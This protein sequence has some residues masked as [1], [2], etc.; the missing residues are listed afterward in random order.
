MTYPWIKTQGAN[1]VHF[2]KAWNEVETL[3]S[4]LKLSGLLVLILY[5]KVSLWIKLQYWFKIHD[6]KTWAQISLS[7]HF[8]FT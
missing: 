3:F 8:Y 4:K 6:E 7:M 2:I 5:S 1:K